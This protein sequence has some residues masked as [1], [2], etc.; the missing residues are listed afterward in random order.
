MTIYR[1]YLL[2]VPVLFCATGLLFVK[3]FVYARI[4]SV[5]GFGLLNQ[6]LLFAGTFAIFASGGLHLLGH[7]LLPQFHA[8]G[9]KRSV[10]DLLG[11]AIAAFGISTLV[12][13]IAISVAIFFRWVPSATTGYAT[14]VFAVAQCLFML[15]LI[16]IKSELR[17]VEHALLSLTR[18]IALLALGVLVAALT[19][20]VAATLAV[21]GLVTLLLA[22]PML[23]GARG[24][25]II[26]RTASI[27]TDQR[28]LE[29][30][31][32]AAMRLLW[33]NGTVTLL[34]A[35]DRWV[36]VAML[37]KRQYGIFALGLLVILVF[38]TLQVIVSVAAY[39]L[40][41]RMIARGAHVRAFNLATLATIIA[42]IATASLYLPF[43]Y[44]LDYVVRDYLPSYADAV[45]VVR[46][47]VI[48]GAFR[49]ADFY[50]SY[51]ILCN[52]EQRLAQ[53]FGLLV[54]LVAATVM[55]I[56]FIGGVV[57]D[58]DRLVLVTLGTS[59][60]GFLLNLTVAV[61]ARQRQ[62]LVTSA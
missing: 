56:H 60:A 20:D 11:S 6:A 5:E 31:L 22:A 46:I 2:Y 15:R 35:I 55:A 16:D 48:A 47:A 12:A 49:L 3:S 17:F 50:A 33:L 18:A 43:V 28:W 39:P 25:S 59:V 27:R 34:Y 44:L 24:L 29:S 10:A 7:K 41:G 57:F 53:L 37:S 21:E 54:I 8:L 58:P 19:H 9:D 26:A 62:R 42:M 45:T 36:G 61:W 38:E 13:G 4:F 14:L 23:R 52:H 1:R 32:P 51:S 30:N 40:M